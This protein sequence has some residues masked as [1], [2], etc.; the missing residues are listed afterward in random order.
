MDTD[1][2]IESKTILSILH[3]RKT[4]GLYS[5]IIT[6]A[7]GAGKSSY[8]LQVLFNVFRSLGYS[9]RE[10]WQMAIDRILYKIPEIVDFIEKAAENEHKDVF[11]WDD[12]GV[13][14]GGVRWLTNQKEMV[15]IESICDT[16]RDSLYGIMFTVPDVRTLSRRIRSYEDHLININFLNDDKQNELK[17]VL[18]KTNVVNYR[19]ARVYRKKVLPSSQV[20]IYRDYYDTFDVMIPDWVYNKYKEKRHTYSKENIAELK[21]HLNNSK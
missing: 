10:S 6:G 3:A 8:S 5:G 1:A 12:A 7:R 4:N 16:L 14:A 11:I 17:Q 9:Q 15:L 21:K 2:G 18:G 13:Y 20:R 19:E